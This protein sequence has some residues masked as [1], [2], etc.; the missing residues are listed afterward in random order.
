[1][2]REFLAVKRGDTIRIYG[3]TVNR[4]GDMMWCYRGKIWYDWRYGE[5][6]FTPSWFM[7]YMT[8]KLV[9]V[10]DCEMEKLRK[11]HGKV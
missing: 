8:E 2:K 6:M 3:T 5:Y 10:V 4:L 7:A 1:M 9:R 11:Q